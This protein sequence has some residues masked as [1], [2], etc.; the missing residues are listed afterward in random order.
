M[1]NRRSFLKVTCGLG[2]GAASGLG[3]LATVQGSQM[4]PPCSSGQETEYEQILAK[5]PKFEWLGLPRDWS[6]VREGLHPFTPER[7]VI[8]TEDGPAERWKWKSRTERWKW[9]AWASL[10][11][12]ERVERQLV[13]WKCSGGPDGLGMPEEKFDIL[14][15]IIN[16]MS[17]YYGRLDLS[18]SWAVRLA[19]REKMMSTSVGPGAGQVHQ[20]QDSKDRIATANGLVDWWIFLFPDGFD[21]DALDQKPVYAV[22]GNVFDQRR[23]DL[24]CP[25][26]GLGQ[27]LARRVGYAKASERGIHE[28]DWKPVASM[29]RITAARFLNHE[30][31]HCLAEVS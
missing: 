28:T 11:V 22:V 12:R 14:G 24:E 16:R 25:V 26:L 9:K 5:S 29:D 27:R 4:V 20:F 23:F 8:L 6:V 19:K 7:V 13:E 3:G 17:S 2:A 18:E 21:F 15:A 1:F 30:L 10:E 31:A